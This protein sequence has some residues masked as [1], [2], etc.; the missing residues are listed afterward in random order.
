[1][2]AVGALRYSNTFAN[3]MA[4]RHEQNG[5]SDYGQPKGEENMD[6]W[7]NKVGREIA[8]EVRKIMGNFGSKLTDRQIE[9][10]TM[11]NKQ[12]FE[13][14]MQNGN[15]IWVDEY[16]RDDGTKVKGHYRAKAS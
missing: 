13:T 16:V 14:Q 3:F 10:E 12:Y 7:N 5:N 15:L 2:Q 8:D 1:M 4:W 6:T 11:Q 9:E